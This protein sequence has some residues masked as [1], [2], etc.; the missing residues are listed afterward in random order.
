MNIAVLT[1]TRDRIEYTQACFASLHEFAGCDYDHFILD[2]GSEDGTPEWLDGEYQADRV[3]GY[4][5]MPD[6]V[7]ISLGMNRLLDELD[8]DDYDVV[9]KFDNDCQLT[10]PNTLREVSRLALVGGC[11]LSPRILGL[12][13]P[14]RPT[15]QVAIDETVIL[16]VPQIGGIFLAAPAWVYDDYRYPDAPV[17]G[18]DDA[19]ICAWFRAKGGTCGYVDELEAWHFETTDGQHDR[20]P[21]YFSRRILEGGPV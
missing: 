5:L 20:Y 21:E 16:D 12:R 8:L 14:P 18:L 4:T 9:V 15:R 19:N 2:Q 13:N 6:N 1:L 10:Q 3:T 17:W 11:L 7:G